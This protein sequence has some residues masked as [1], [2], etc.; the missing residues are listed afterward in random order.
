MLLLDERLPYAPKERSPRAARILAIDDDVAAIVARLKKR[1][2]T[3]PYLKPFV[4]ARGAGPPRG[5]ARAEDKHGSRLSGRFPR[6]HE[7]RQ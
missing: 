7:E 5:S 6:L 4:T 3:G 1:G 2:F